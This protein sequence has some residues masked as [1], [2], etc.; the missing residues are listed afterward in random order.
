HVSVNKLSPDDPLMSYRDEHG[1]LKVLTKSLFL[2][3]C[4]EAWSGHG[5]PKFS[6]HSFRIG[7]TT[8]LLQCGVDPKVVK[9]CGRWKS[10][11]F[12]RYWRDLHTIAS[13]H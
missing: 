6:G 2:K 3:V 9:R 13:I 12:A 10:S 4:N 5:Y 11:A 1:R 8:Y 7:G